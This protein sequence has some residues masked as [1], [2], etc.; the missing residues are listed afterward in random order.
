[1]TSLKNKFREEFLKSFREELFKEDKV[2][3]EITNDMSSV[4]KTNIVR[5][6]EEMLDLY[7]D[8]DKEGEIIPL[9][10]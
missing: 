6:D 5:T 3:N 9:D 2:E 10:F 8:S 7:K 4:K 1:M